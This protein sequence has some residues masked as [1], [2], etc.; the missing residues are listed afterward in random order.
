MTI[1]ENNIKMLYALNAMRKNGPK[2]KRYSTIVTSKVYDHIK[3][4]LST[5]ISKRTS[6]SGNPMYGKSAVKDNNLKWYNNGKDNIYVSEGSEPIGYSL[7]RIIPSNYR[8][9][10][11]RA[12]ISPSG[13]IFESVHDAAIAYNTTAKVIRERIRRHDPNKKQRKNSSMWRYD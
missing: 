1:G 3:N 7:G 4:E 11:K 10:K 13:E 9:Y 12:C 8:R 2:Q 5:H 6:G